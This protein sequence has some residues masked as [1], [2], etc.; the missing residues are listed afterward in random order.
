MTI[1]YTKLNNMLKKAIKE[2]IYDGHIDQEELSP[3]V[4]N[5]LAQIG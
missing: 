3:E 5:A 4:F 1:D 2:D